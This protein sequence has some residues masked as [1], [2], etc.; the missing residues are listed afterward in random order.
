[1]APQFAPLTPQ[2]GVLR[3]KVSKSGLAALLDECLPKGMYF[4]ALAH[5][6]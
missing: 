1:M 5:T 2:G 3:A 6:S 4:V